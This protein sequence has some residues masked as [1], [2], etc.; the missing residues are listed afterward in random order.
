[1]RVNEDTVSQRSLGDSK[2]YIGDSTDTLTNKVCAVDIHDGGLI[3]CDA[4][5]QY[6]CFF[7]QGP[8]PIWGT[9]YYAM[10]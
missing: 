10:S 3:P 7:R 4:T 2:L 9:L 5:G 6:L 8:H 1:M